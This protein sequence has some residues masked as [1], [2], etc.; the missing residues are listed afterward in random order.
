[1]K[2]PSEK[3]PGGQ[4]KQPK[5][6]SDLPTHVGIVTPKARGRLAGPARKR[7]YSHLNSEKNPQS[8]CNDR[9]VRLDRPRKRGS[10][11]LGSTRPAMRAG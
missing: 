7:G 10:T 4:S 5:S 1:M 2:R 11:N 6:N 9:E 3:V 8:L